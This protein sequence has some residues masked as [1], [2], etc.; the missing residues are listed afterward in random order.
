MPFS[1]IHKGIRYNA[2]CIFVGMSERSHHFY[3]YIITQ[4]SIIAQEEKCDNDE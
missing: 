1:L 2:H 3:V 4:A